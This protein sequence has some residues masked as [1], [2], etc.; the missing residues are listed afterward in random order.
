MLILSDSC[1]AWYSRSY[2]AASIAATVNQL[3]ADF[4]PELRAGWL[5]YITKT[6]AAGQARARQGPSGGRDTQIVDE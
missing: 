5:A 1:R 6:F 3:G 2:V 4:R